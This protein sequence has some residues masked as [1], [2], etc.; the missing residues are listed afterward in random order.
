MKISYEPREQVPRLAWLAHVA[1]GSIRVAHGPWVETRP[2]GFVAGTW[3]EGYSEF[4]FDQAPNLFG[5]GGRARDG[6]IVFATPTHQIDRL[7]LMEIDGVCLVSN[8]LAFLLSEADD[9]PD[10]AHPNYFFD[11]VRH[12]RRGVSMGECSLPTDRGNAF[13]L[14]TCCNLT[15]DAQMRVAGEEKN[16]GPEPESYQ[17]HRDLLGAVVRRVFLNA[18]DARRKHAYQPIAAISRGYDSPAAAVLAAQAG[19]IRA[20]SFSWSSSGSRIVDDHGGPIAE[21]LGMEVHTFDRSDFR[22]LPVDHQAEFFLSPAAHG[23]TGLGQAEE[24]LEGSVLVT[25]RHGETAWGRALHGRAPKLRGT[26]NQILPGV[27]SIEQRLRCGYIQLHPAYIGALH[28]SALH[29]VNNH[30][31][32]DDWDLGTG[33]DRPMARRIAEEGGVPRGLFGNVRA[34]GAGGQPRLSP[35]SLAEFLKFY[36]ANVPTNIRRRLRETNTPRRLRVF[37]YLVRLR[38]RFAG[39]PLV[40]RLLEFLQVDRAHFLWKMRN[41]YIFHWGLIRTMERYRR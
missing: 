22:D 9:G 28:G 23:D 12:Y 8:S 35:E 4:N 7:Y 15:I 31:E 29:R 1:P 37:S 10:L 27:E 17:Q 41:L 25:G 26:Y 5:S 32:L 40:E 36:E 13:K 33:Y 34:G 3:D 39:R 11:L 30:P 2:Q 6:R 16:P 24:L 21:A 38:L 20:L 18:S 19:C 14:F